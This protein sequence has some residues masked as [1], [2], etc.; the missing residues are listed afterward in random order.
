[1]DDVD[2]SAAAALRET[3]E[4][5]NLKRIRLVFVEIQDHVRAELDRSK[6]TELVGPEYLFK[7]VYDLENSYRQSSASPVR[8]L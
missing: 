3:Y 6:I 1:M 4:L 8:A 5:L 7:T 2:Y